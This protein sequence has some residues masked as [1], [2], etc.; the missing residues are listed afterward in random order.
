MEQKVPKT[1]NK[2]NYLFFSTYIDQTA[3]KDDAA[4][5]PGLPSRIHVCRRLLDLLSHQTRNRSRTDGFT[6]HTIPSSGIS[7]SKV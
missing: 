2:F 5:G 4:P 7:G 3:T 6:C 1:N